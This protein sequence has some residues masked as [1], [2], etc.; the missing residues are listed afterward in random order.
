MSPT[1]SSEPILSPEQVLHCLGAIARCIH[2]CRTLDDILYITAHTVRK[3]L[4][5]DQVLISRFQPI[6]TN[7]TIVES[8]DS[9]WTSLL[10]KTF[11]EPIALAACKESQNRVQ[12]MALI[13]EKL[14]QFSNLAK[15]DFQEYIKTLVQ[16]LFRSYEAHKRTSSFTVKVN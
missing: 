7:T 16:E 4:Q 2:K 12:A 8:V 10:G 15:I 6:E 9:N 3:L 11:S 1:S 5:T 13:H 14:Y